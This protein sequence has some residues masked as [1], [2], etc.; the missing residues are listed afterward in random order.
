LHK[1]KRNIVWI[2]SYPKSGNTWFRIFLSNLFSDSSEPVNINELYRTPIASSR[3]LFDRYSCIDSSDL[4]VIEINK[5][6][7]LVYKMMSEESS[8][9]LFLKTHDS[10]ELNID[11]QPIFPTDITKGVIYLVRNPLD[12][13]ISFAKH[14]NKDL[15]ETIKNINNDSFSLCKNQFRLHNQL[16]QHLSSWSNHIK[17]WTIDSKLPVH[18]IR[19]EDMIHSP[20]KTFS[21]AVK[22]L[23]LDYSNDRI[24]KAVKNCS[25]EI[26][27]N[28]EERFGFHEKAIHSE[29]FFRK[30]EV[31]DWK[32]KLSNRQ[33][34]TILSGNRL[35]MK[36][37]GYLPE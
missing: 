5:L 12:I 6:R 11:K 1:L 4:S 17:S 18:L 30:G 3:S 20:I 27:R 35:V 26:L 23:E 7:P 2:A 15:D 24:T 25:F 32:T 22:Y 33:V 13:A 29:Y 14:N 28:Q 19:F 10:W 16:N 37:F 34:K 8:D 36:Q 21:N 31:G 9:L